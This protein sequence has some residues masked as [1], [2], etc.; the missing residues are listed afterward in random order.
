MKIRTD[1]VTN[2]SS[3]SFIFKEKD[4]SPENK[5][6]MLQRFEELLKEDAEFC[7]EEPRWITDSDIEEDQYWDRQFI[8]GFSVKRIKD[9]DLREILET[10]EWYADDII[11]MIVQDDCE[12]ENLPKD[13]IRKLAHFSVLLLIN[14][15]FHNNLYYNQ[16][17]F[18][19]KLR[20]KSERLGADEIERLIFKEIICQRLFDRY[21]F[22]YNLYILRNEEMTEF[23]K[24]CAGVT[25]GE[26][27]EEVVDAK[28]MYFDN[29]ECSYLGYQALKELPECILCCNHMG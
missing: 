25:A 2:S 10:A 19:S 9:H 20:E 13:V 28:Y 17:K 27:L 8:E 3:S 6:R 14:Y 15:N 29:R 22:L 21:I 5:K 16:Y 18:D 7:R 12:I 1:F 4:I 23:A 11:N 24:E 26:I